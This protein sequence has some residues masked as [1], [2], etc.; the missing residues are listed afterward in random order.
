GTHGGSH[1]FVLGGVAVHED[2]AP[3]L[4]TELDQLVIKHLGRVPV[5][6]EDYELHA[7][8]LRNA[9][10][11]SPQTANKSQKHK[12]VSIWAHE[13][14]KVRLG[15][16]SDAYKLVANFSPADPSLPLAF[17]GVVVDRHFRPNWTPMEREEFT[18]E[19][20]LN[21]FDTGLRMSQRR[22]GHANKGLVIHDRRV[23]AERDIQSWTSGW[24]VAAGKVG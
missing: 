19:V 22:T 5:N 1:S 12:P 24:R 6:L 15:L 8:E 21:K 13:T 4:Q 3:R 17:F 16:L 9:K 18:Y 20:L 10:K 2:D 14:R 7:T 11:P 23:V